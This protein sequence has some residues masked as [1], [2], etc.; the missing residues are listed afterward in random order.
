MLQPLNGTFYAEQS[1]RVNGNHSSP[2]QEGRPSPTS[3]SPRSRAGETGAALDLSLDDFIPSHL[4]K[5]PSANN[6]MSPASPRA[7]STPQTVRAPSR[8]RVPVIRNCGSNTL[9]FEFHDT[10]PRTVNNGMSQQWKTAQWKSASNWYPT[11]PAKE[12]RPLKSRAAAAA[13]AAAAPVPCPADSATRPVV[14]GAAQ[15]SWSA[16][17]T[18]DGRRKEKR[19]VKYD[20][21]GPVDESGMPIAS[22][23]SVDSPRDWYR[24]MFQQ[25][26]SKLPGQDWDICYNS[27]GS[28]KSALDSDSFV[29]SRC[30]ASKVHAEKPT[31]GLGIKQLLLPSEW[32]GL[33]QTILVS[34][35]S[36]FS[37]TMILQCLPGIL[38]TRRT[39]EAVDATAKEPR[40][41]FDYEPGK[42]SVLEHPNSP[43]KPP[44]ALPAQHRTSSP[45]IEELLEKELQ[46]LSEE[47]DKD[48]KAIEI[49]QLARKCSS[50]ASSSA[51]VPS[52]AFA[53]RRSP[54]PDHS[55]YPST[56]QNLP[57]AQCHVS[58]SPRMEK[59]SPGIARNNWNSSPPR[60]DPLR[61]V[62]RIP[63]S[64]DAVLDSPTKKEENKMKAARLKFDF[65]AESPK[66][67]TLQKGDIVYIHKEVDR[68]WLE[69]EHHGRVGIFPANYVEVLPPTEIPKPIKSP[70]IQVL[71]YGEAVAQY[72]FKGDLL[73][74]LSFRK[75]ERIC[76]IRRVDQNW[77]EGRISG[78]S[79]QGIFPANYVQVLKEPRVK[80]TEEF[81][82]SPNLRA[83]HS[84]SPSQL[85]SPSPASRWQSD[86]SPST[87]QG[88]LTTDALSSSSSHSGF[89][90]P[91]SPKLEHSEA[92]PHRPQSTPRPALFSLQ[93]PATASSIPQPVSTF[94]KQ[95]VPRPA[96]S[97]PA[98]QP[99]ALFMYEVWAG[100]GGVQRLTLLSLQG[101]SLE[102]AAPQASQP[103][104][105]KRPSEAA[106]ADIQW[107]PYKALYQYRPQNE[108]ELELQEG[109]RVDV[110]QQCDDGW[111]V[112]V[113]R[114]TQ[115]FGTFPGNYVAPV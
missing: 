2:S 23:S 90:F 97:A 91:V 105:T 30:Q 67:L 44:T 107:T 11:W 54:L 109:D 102:A 83:A 27:R 15:P 77:Y 21:I 104:S 68:N 69:G 13:A 74:E 75:G 43:K 110:M 29:S 78:T 47:L 52:P 93:S 88:S 95:E 60:N 73:V 108:D 31:S 45:P 14:N 3:L 106:E 42:S 114:R 85:H 9:N 18:K 76:L 50:A 49:R 8:R 6:S 22:R 38:W 4:Q 70:T 57:A 99:R 72:N 65:Q 92:V 103:R 51:R 33:W 81:P 71:E 86:T 53:A 25:I 80:N 115:K 5:R 61:H 40:S 16:T 32:F 26:H 7:T 41:I 24:S 111:F 63:E 66:E 55:A 1:L 36:P 94:Q 96:V 19:W 56:G 82:P 79:R 39:W 89:T 48:I 62:G 113:S 35:P 37:L 112:G 28:L 20:G 64:L 34:H 59:G 98:S 58:A 46:Q 84:G 17:W 12:I 87:L 101:S 100:T 10:S